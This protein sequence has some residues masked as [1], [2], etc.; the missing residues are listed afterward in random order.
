M[1][2]A[3][4]PSDTLI[5]RRLD[6]TTLPERIGIKHGSKDGRSLEGGDTRKVRAAVGGSQGSQAPYDAQS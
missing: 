1:R 5:R 6:E 4:L 2:R 3:S